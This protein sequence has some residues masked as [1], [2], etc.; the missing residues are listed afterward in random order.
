[1][2]RYETF[3]VL[4]DHQL[5]AFLAGE[6]ARLDLRRLDPKGRL[7]A[8]IGRFLQGV[9]V[10]ENE[11]LDPAAMPE[12]LREVLILPPHLERSR[13]LTFGQQVVR[14]VRGLDRDD[15]R[16]SIHAD[17]RHLVVDEYQDVDPAQE[18]LIEL[19]TG[20][21]VELCVVGDD[22]QAIYRW[23]GSDVSNIVTFAAR[24]PGVATFEIV[25]N[26]RSRPESSTHYPD[27]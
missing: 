1:V 26:R 4:D 5:T 6:A 22:D 15:V 3:D 9:D 19:L 27:G 7:F 16:A 12:P 11:L 17:L 20:R 13:L 8:S 21:A 2:P 23:R 14:A 10:V 18:R 25:T 24:Y